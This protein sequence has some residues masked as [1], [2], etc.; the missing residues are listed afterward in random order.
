MT[1][2][3]SGPGSGILVTGAH[4]SGTTWV[5]KMLT[6]S[7]EAAY[8][9]EPFN[10]WR[11]PGVFK[12]PIRHWYTY[13][14]P[15]NE[16]DFLAPFRHILHYRYHLWEEVKS[17][18]SIKD[19][20]RMFRDSGNFLSGWLFKKRPLIKDPFAFFSTPWI[21]MRFGCRVVITVRHPAAFASSLKRL[22]WPFDFRDLLDQPLLVRDW[23]AP[24]VP[25]IQQQL[26]QSDNVIGQSSLLWKIIYD[27]ALQ[28]RKRIPDLLIVKHED[29]SNDPITGYQSLYRDLGLQF[30]LRAGRMI[31]RSSEAGNP[32]EIASKNIYGTR[33]D[34]RAN[35]ENWKHR[36][37]P[38]EIKCIRNATE[39]V[40]SQFYSDRDWQ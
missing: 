25:E 34:S 29:L 33:V 21:I 31:A 39:E 6:T 18:R 32:T 35:L 30:T 28:L 27:V 10:R 22:S 38:E 36:L 9:S 17:L 7:G 8:I 19:S 16:G 13:V 37:T 24:F 40:A 14:C 2:T 15:E 4:R 12:A 11:R 5:G 23:V 26:A 20:L 1:L 3:E